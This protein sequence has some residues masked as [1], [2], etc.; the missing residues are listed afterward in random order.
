MFHHINRHNPESL[1]LAGKKELLEFIL[2]FLSSTW[3]INNPY[4]KAK[5]VQVRRLLQIVITFS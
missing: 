4:L 5:L 1:E 2:I 3:Y